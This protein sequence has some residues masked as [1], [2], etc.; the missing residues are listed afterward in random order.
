MCEIDS[1]RL[2]HFP[3]TVLMNIREA[4]LIVIQ[5]LP[6]ILTERKNQKAMTA[7]DEQ[8]EPEEKNRVCSR[9]CSGSRKAGWM[10]YPRRGRLREEILIA[11]ES[12]P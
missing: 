2:K 4:I 5:A 6:R 9:S 1:E 3:K 11:G 10:P 8:N 7:T 12:V